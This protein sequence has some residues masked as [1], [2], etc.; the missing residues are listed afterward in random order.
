M[1][2][3]KLA[4]GLPETPQKTMAGD[5]DP[6]IAG[7]RR[8]DHVS[9]PEAVITELTVRKQGGR[10][11]SVKERLSFLS[12]G[13]HS[14]TSVPAG[15]TKACLAQCEGFRDTGYTHLSKM[16]VTA[17]SWRPTLS[18]TSILP[19]FTHQQVRLFSKDF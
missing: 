2:L 13:A 18:A 19:S 8:P 1:V 11:R 14:P 15:R 6:T 12:L 9:L 4:P 16:Q 7:R 5:T 10:T 3:L 17:T